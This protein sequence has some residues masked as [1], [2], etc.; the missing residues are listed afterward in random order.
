[1]SEITAVVGASADETKYSNMAIRN[2]LEAGQEVIC[3]SPKPVGL[4]G[5]DEYNE[6]EEINKNVDTVTVYISPKRQD[7]MLQDLLVLKPTRVIFNP[8]T[9]NPSAYQDLE[10]ADIKVMEACTLVMLSTGQY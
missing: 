1:M 3:I 5:C 2:L 7:K 9:E 6:L 4:D 8:G 10:N